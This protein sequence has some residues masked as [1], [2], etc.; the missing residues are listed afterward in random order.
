MS[1]N[2]LQDRLDELKKLNR[3]RFDYVL[4]RSRTRSITEALE[5]IRL[6]YGWWTGFSKEERDELEALADELHKEKRM[7]AEMMLMQSLVDAVKVKVDGLK[8]KDRNIQQGAA[9]EIMDRVLGKATQ[10]TDNKVTVSGVIRI[11]RDD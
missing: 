1:E 9:T 6:S 8:S 5:E 10:P 2:A 3:N 4:V 11:V 7:Q